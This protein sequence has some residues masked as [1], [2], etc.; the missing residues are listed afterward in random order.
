MWVPRAKAFRYT[1]CPVS[2]VMGGSNFLLFDEIAYARQ[3]TGNSRMRKQY[4]RVA[5]S[6][7]GYLDR[8]QEAGGANLR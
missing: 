1:S 2:E 5:P 4:T 3:Q 8:L 6:F 7:I